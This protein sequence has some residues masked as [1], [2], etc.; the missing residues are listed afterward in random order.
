MNLRLNL[1]P[2]HDIKGSN[3]YKMDSLSPINI[4][5]RAV[6]FLVLCNRHKMQLQ[7]YLTAIY[8]QV[9]RECGFLVIICIMNSV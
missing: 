6:E 7:R 9:L 8:L 5:R 1:Q 3:L 4:D 2:H